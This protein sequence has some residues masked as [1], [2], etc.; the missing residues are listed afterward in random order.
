[1]SFFD[2][3]TLEHVDV[4]DV[5][6]LCGPSG[7]GLTCT[8]LAYGRSVDLGPIRCSSATTGVTCRYRSAPR[9][10]FRVAREGYAVF[11]A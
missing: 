9:A 4:G 5:G 1:M 11:R 2:G 7:S 6:P 10:G 3:F 8:T